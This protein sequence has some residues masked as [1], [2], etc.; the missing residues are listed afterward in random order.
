VY[1]NNGLPSTS[2]SSGSL[3]VKGGVGIQGN[4]FMKGGLFVSSSGI[5]SAGMT[6]NTSS[7]TEYMTALPYASSETISFTTNSVYYVSGTAT[8]ITSLTI[9]SMPVTPLASY[10]FSFLLASPGSSA[11]YI[12][13][14]TVNVNGT[15]VSLLGTIT[16]GTPVGYI[17]QQITVFNT[18]STAT[19]TWA[20][21]NTAT[22]Y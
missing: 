15:N 2:I 9:T 19:P 12:S 6:V 21:I 3:L 11:N 1:V 14:S 10:T 13:A 22:A 4:V 5:S 17:L 8:P 16:L 18:S 20:A 7:Y